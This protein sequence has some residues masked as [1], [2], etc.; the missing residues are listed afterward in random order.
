LAAL[1]YDVVHRRRD[2]VYTLR[3]PYHADQNPRNSSAPR[4][5]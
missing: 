3:L 4:A 1:G 2:G 5:A